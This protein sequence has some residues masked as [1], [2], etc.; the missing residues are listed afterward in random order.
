M[1]VIPD[2]ISE[3]F[4]LAETAKSAEGKTA[5]LLKLKFC[6]AKLD[7][8]TGGN[9]ISLCQ[10]TADFVGRFDDWMDKEGG[11]SP[12]SRATYLR[13]L[14]AVC[15]LAN[16]NGASADLSAFTAESRANKMKRSPLPTPP[17]PPEIKRTD[18]RRHWF[19]MKCRSI[20]SVEMETQIHSDFPGTDTFR[21]DVERM[22]KTRAG[23]RKQAVELL[24]GTL[25]F[26]TT[27]ALCRKMKYRYH[28][29]AYIYDYKSGDMREMAVVSPDDLKA[30]MYINN[31]SPKRIICHFPD[32]AD[33]PKIS[34]GIRVRINEGQ[35]KGTEATITRQSK[36]NPLEAMVTI[37][38][39]LLQV[40]FLAPVPWRFLTPLTD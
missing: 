16:K 32:E 21:T 25:F 5:A 40:Y 37:H 3:A 7:Q 8:F 30:F 33:C 31:I 29:L 28:D 12:N 39:P 19:V 20:T 36:D 26:R 38:F 17:A 18:R 22:V 13:S 14:H 10:I 4:R 6:K 35:F 11:L 15:R 2:T 9:D 1:N 24:R 27:K 23:R 34:H